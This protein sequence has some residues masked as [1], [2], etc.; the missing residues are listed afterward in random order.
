MVFSITGVSVSR[1][2]RHPIHPTASPMPTP[3]HH[4]EEE[5]PEHVGQR[6]HRAD[7]RHRHLVG[8]QR[9]GVVHEPLAAEDGHEPAR[10]AELAGD[11]GGRHRV[12]RRHDGTQSEGH[13]PGHP[14]HHR[15][16]HHRHRHHGGQHQAHGQQQDGLQVDAELAC[17]GVEGGVVD[18]RRQEDQQHQVGLELHAVLGRD[19]RHRDAGHDQEDGIGDPEPV[20]DGGDGHDADEQAD[21]I[22]NAD[23]GRRSEQ[24][25]AGTRTTYSAPAPEAGV[26]GRQPGRWQTASTLLPSGSRT[27][28]PK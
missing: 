16:D 6:D 11:L 17:R 4:G 23:H 8:G 2:I 5:P 9:G 27:K 25:A 24:V 12:G 10:E 14:A 20:G 3:T 15:V 28:A 26:P 22:G 18:E 7:R 21:A 1:S 13:R 19:Q